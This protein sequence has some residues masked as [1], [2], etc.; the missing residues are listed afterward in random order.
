M[1]LTDVDVHPPECL[2]LHFFFCVFCVLLAIELDEPVSPAEPEVTLTEFF[3]TFFE[4][5]L[6][7]GS[8]DITHE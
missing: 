2:S 8:R 5:S 7:S 3:E 1:L 4:V 6:G